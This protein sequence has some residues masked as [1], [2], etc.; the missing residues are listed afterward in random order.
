MTRCPPQTP[1]VI[2]AIMSS[3]ILVL[4]LRP[5]ISRRSMCGVPDHAECG[6]RHG[7]RQAKGSGG[8][9]SGVLDAAPQR[10]KPFARMHACQ[11]GALIPAAETRR[12]RGKEGGGVPAAVPDAVAQMSTP[13]SECTRVKWA[14]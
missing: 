10:S 14:T 11:R 8:V 12:S 7:G 13:L 1:S 3:K 6:P 2:Y 4:L 9:L 5:C